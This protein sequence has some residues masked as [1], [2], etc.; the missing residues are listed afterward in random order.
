MNFQMPDGRWKEINEHFRLQF[1]IQNRPSTRGSITYY[2]RRGS[3]HNL[4][5]E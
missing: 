1:P 4:I 3:R 2:I 5:F